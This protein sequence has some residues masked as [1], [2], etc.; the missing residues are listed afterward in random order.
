MQSI[1]WLNACL[2]K[3]VSLSFNHLPN[4]QPQRAK[5]RGAALFATSRSSAWLAAKFSFMGMQTTPE[6]L[7]SSD[8]LT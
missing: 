5:L 7:T 8:C 4:K 6:Q 3:I 2:D 1:H